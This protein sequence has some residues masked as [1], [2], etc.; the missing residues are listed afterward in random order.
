MKTLKKIPLFLLIGSLVMSLSAC[1]ESRE[2]VL[3][4]VSSV[5][6]EIDYLNQRLTEEFP[7]YEIFKSIQELE[8]YFSK[9]YMDLF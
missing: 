4:Y 6:Y 5:D 9:N 8:Q 2:R 1:G 7:Q 3:I